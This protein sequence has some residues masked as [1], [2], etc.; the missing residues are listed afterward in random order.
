ML[1]NVRQSVP[2][3]PLPSKF[4]SSSCIKDASRCRVNRPKGLKQATKPSVRRG[5]WTTS[6]CT[7]PYGAPHCAITI[8][9]IDAQRLS[10]SLGTLE[11]SCNS[12]LQAIGPGPTWA[13][14]QG[15]KV[16]TRSPLDEHLQVPRCPGGQS[17]P[18]PQSRHTTDASRSSPGLPRCPPG[19]HW[20]FSRFLTSTTLNTCSGAFPKEFPSFRRIR[21]SDS[22]SL[23]SMALCKFSCFP[24]ISLHT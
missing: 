7:V 17:G 14:F 23:I 6:V 13:L 1:F 16:D 15:S 18:Q 21:N 20:R 11:V 24:L 8:R 22:Y 19:Q 10:R 4:Y 12:K 9:R 2:T 5:R 3:I